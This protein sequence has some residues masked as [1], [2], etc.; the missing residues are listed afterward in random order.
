M[1]HVIKAFSLK[2][3]PIA[4]NT[5]AHT[6]NGPFQ[7]SFDEIRIVY[8]LY[9]IEQCSISGH[10]FCKKL[11]NTWLYLIVNYKS[12]RIYR[13]LNECP[14]HAFLISEQATFLAIFQNKNVQLRE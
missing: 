14:L 11:V 8:I 3:E 13:S 7:F 10:F 6:Q 12:I 9:S 5:H 4:K 1:Y 2:I